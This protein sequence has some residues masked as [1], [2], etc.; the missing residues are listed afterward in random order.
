[1]LERLNEL[2]RKQNLTETQL[3]SRL[4]A[5]PDVSVEFRYPFE[6]GVGGHALA[7]THELELRET[8]EELMNRS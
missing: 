4:L 2:R 8:Y 3:R 7:L 6:H 5:S 1:M